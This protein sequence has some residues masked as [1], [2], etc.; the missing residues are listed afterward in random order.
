MNECR[1]VQLSSKARWKAFTEECSLAEQQS[2]NKSV[3]MPM[4]LEWQ[5]VV[6]M[7]RCLYTFGHIVY[8]QGYIHNPMYPVGVFN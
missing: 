2:G 5:H 4:I 3:L 8:I 7:V 1:S 6:V